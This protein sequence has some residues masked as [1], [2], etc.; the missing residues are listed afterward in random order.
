MNRRI[1]VLCVVP[2][3]LYPQHSGGE[4]RVVSLMR[5]LRR[6]YEFTVL[7]FEAPGEELAQAAGALSLERNFGIRTIFCP[8][9][10]RLAPPRGKP[11]I[12]VDYWDPAL[13]LR[14]RAAVAALTIDLVQLEFTQMAQYAACV[15]DLVPVVL[16]EHDSSILTPSDSYY[17]TGDDGR[18]HSR[19]VRA[20]MK[21]AFAHCQRI[22]TVSRADAVRLEDLAG[23]SKLRVVPTGADTRRL[24]FRPGSGRR[25]ADALFI[26]HYP[27]F[28]NEDAAVHLCRDV[29][30]RLK[31]RVPQARV[32]LVGSSPT[33]AVRAL[34]SPDV[35]VIGTVPDVAP[36]LWSNGL[37]LA[38]MRRGFGIKGKILEAFSA[39]LPVV[40]TPTACEAMPGAK[41]GREFLV[42]RDAD[43]LAAAAAR[44]VSDPALAARLARNA[45]RF[46]VA[47]F[48][49]SVQAG[50]LDS[51]LKEA[52]AA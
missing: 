42:G 41:D 20:Y 5:A 35:H 31:R 4:I 36:H 45:R 33:E 50:L 11:A 3:S 9:T 25:S 26:G 51:V 19:R 6:D 28:P 32:M 8:R 7:T 27:H 48:D 24:A 52:L 37:F 30:P 23:R 10:P 47:R 39:G 12:A 13:A 1:R 44:I 17:R 49:W 46:V 22:V 34:A 18:D 29:L 14:I 2:R 40:A 21:S 16:T 43:A 15:S 38:P